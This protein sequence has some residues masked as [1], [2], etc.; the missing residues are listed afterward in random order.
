MRNHLRAY[1][2]GSHTR[3]TGGRCRQGSAGHTGD[4]RGGCTGRRA[5]AQSVRYFAGYLQRGWRRCFGV[6]GVLHASRGIRW[7]CWPVKTRGRTGLLDPVNPFC[8]QSRHHHGGDHAGGG[9][10]AFEFT[11]YGNSYGGVATLITWLVML[12]VAQKD[13]SDGGPGLVQSITQCFM[14][15][16]VMAMEMQLSVTGLV[17]FIKGTV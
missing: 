14:G 16:I 8:G 10:L 17:A 6:D 12:R 5:C 7:F 11:G 15:L 3:T 13:S 2:I 9:A 4:P 1:S